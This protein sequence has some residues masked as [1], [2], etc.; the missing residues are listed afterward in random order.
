ML[1]RR[2]LAIRKDAIT[3]REIEQIKRDLIITPESNDYQ[4]SIPYKIYSESIHYIITP[5]NYKRRSPNPS[6]PMSTVER[7][8]RALRI[9]IE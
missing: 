9:N 7:S 6:A 3:Q 1:T 5:R 8:G 4:Q 2:G